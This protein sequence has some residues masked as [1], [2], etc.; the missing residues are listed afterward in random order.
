MAQCGMH[1]LRINAHPL[2]HN[3]CYIHPRKIRRVVVAT[4]MHIRRVPEARILTSV[5]SI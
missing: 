1:A 3:M 5:R 4:A 2:H